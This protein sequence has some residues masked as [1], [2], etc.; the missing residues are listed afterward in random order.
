VI[1]R[2]ALLML[3]GREP[4]AMSR[5]SNLLHSLGNTTVLCAVDN[6]G[7][8]VKPFPVPRWLFFVA[9][10]PCELQLATTGHAVQ[11]ADPDWARHLPYVSAPHGTAVLTHQQTHIGRERGA[12]PSSRWG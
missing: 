7:V 8:V 6:E 9:D 5:S 2:R 1:F 10:A 4:A 11:M 3:R 12:G